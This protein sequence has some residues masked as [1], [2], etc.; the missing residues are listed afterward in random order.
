MPIQRFQFAAAQ[1][2]QPESLLGRWAFIDSNGRRFDSYDMTAVADS[3]VTEGGKQCAY[4]NTA[5]GTVRCTETT[6]D[7]ATHK[8]VYVSDYRFTPGTA[9]RA[10]GVSM[11]IDS[12]GQLTGDTRI[13]AVMRAVDRHG[14]LA[15]LGPLIKP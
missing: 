4:E 9:G 6:Y 12:Q 15:G 10:L 14:V 8:T 7:S 3:R 11:R 13:V 5:Y 2:P 1:A